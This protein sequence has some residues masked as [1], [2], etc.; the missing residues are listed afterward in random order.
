MT[1]RRPNGEFK[2]DHQKYFDIY[3]N[4]TII[5]EEESHKTGNLCNYNYN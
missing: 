4:L 3:S 1:L 2:E 5:L